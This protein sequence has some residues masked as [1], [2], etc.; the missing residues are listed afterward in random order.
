M[1]ENF[2]LLSPA[3]A[4]GGVTP[5]LLRLISIFLIWY[6]VVLLWSVGHE[7]AAIGRFVQPLQQTGK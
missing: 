4:A 1:Y 7:L 5:W 3:S 2:A 6:G